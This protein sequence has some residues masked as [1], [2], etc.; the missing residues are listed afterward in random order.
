[1]EPGL[2]G[3]FIFKRHHNTCSEVKGTIFCE[4]IEIYNQTL[5]VQFGG[6][7]SNTHL[8]VIPSAKYNFTGRKGVFNAEVCSSKKRL[9]RSCKEEACWNMCPGV[10][11]AVSSDIKCVEYPLLLALDSTASAEPPLRATSIKY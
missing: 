10:S 11:S 9:Q 4:M 7:A 5:G 6:V 8:R 3:H 1:M 2:R